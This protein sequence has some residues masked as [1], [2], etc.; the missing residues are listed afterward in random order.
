MAKA[1]GVIVLPLAATGYVARQIWDK[2]RAEPE[3]YL[4]KEIDAAFFEEIGPQVTS[5]GAIL[6]ALERCITRIVA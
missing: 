5:E 2:M 6:A 3:V 1:R 4:T